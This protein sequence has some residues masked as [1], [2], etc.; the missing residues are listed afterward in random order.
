DD[1]MLSVKTTTPG[2]DIP[3][4]PLAKQCPLKGMPDCTMAHPGSAEFLRMFIRT[5]VVITVDEP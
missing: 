3:I 5:F 1:D 2:A 4:C